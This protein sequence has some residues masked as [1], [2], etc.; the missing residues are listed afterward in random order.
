M[1]PMVRRTS[2]AS[3]VA[4][5]VFCRMAT[6]SPCSVRVRVLTSLL[7]LRKLVRMS[8]SWAEERVTVWSSVRESRARLDR[9]ACRF[10]SPSCE[11]STLRRLPVTSEMSAAILFI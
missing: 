2:R 9:I 8:S 7:K 10:S 6:M 3:A 11:P 5:R 4:S 1:T